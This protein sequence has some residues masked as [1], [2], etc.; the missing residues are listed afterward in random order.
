MVIDSFELA[1]LPSVSFGEGVLQRVPEIAASF[2]SRML[3]L[4]GAESF[5]TSRHWPVFSSA[6]EQHGLTWDTCIVEEEPS[7]E[8]IDEIVSKFRSSNVELLVGI[9]GG[10]VIDAAKA[11]A[12]LLIPGNSVADHLEGVGKGVAYEGPAVPWIAVPTTAGTGSEATKNAVLSV[13]GH[14]GFKKS[15]RHA[16]LVAR[17]AVIDPL[18]LESCPP[19][20]VAADGMD[21]LTQ[22]IES[23]VSKCSNPFTDA[24][25]MSALEAVR[26]GLMPWYENRD[27]VSAARERMAYASWISGVALAQTGLGAV[28]G[29]ASPLGAFFPVPHGVVCGTLVA[30]AIQINVAAMRERQPDDRALGRYARVHAVLAGTDRVDTEEGPEALVELVRDWT[31]RLD[32]PR[33]GAYGVRGS[34]V[35]RVVD[36]S[37]GS[38]MHTNP[39]ELTDEEIAAIL[40]ERL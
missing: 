23:F 12:G 17:H 39:I 3:L 35:E 7:P 1:R 21:A 16:T 36:H 10:S 5:R 24:L 22:L 2:G 11:V 19:E 40:R 9:G 20:L 25:V 32:L 27:D 18:L 26:D 31:L 29:L 28:H 34:D 37:R 38:S 14:E 6:L 33:L 15:F 4:T 30:S 13:R 8:R